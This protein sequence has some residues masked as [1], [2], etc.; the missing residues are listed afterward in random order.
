MPCNL[1][2]MTRTTTIEFT[3]CTGSAVKLRHCPA[4]VKDEAPTVDNHCAQREGDSWVLSQETG[5]V[6]NLKLFRGGRLCDA[7]LLFFFFCCWCFAFQ[8]GRLNRPS[9]APS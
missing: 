8:R 3:G 4:T 9:P 5:P 2:E 6:S 1:T 7:L